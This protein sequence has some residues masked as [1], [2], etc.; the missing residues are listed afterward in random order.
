M[1]VRD[2]AI[3]AAPLGPKNRA[4]IE[5]PPLGE[6]AAAFAGAAR[7]SAV[8]LRRLGS[9]GATA[10]ND[11]TIEQLTPCAGIRS[12]SLPESRARA[13]RRWDLSAS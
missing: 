6:V 13:P 8:H 7:L 10:G 5:F 12:A 11:H 2:S 3:F 1:R 9:D 4:L